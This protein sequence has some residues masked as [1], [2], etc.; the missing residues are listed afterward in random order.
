LSCENYFF[1]KPRLI[2]ERQGK[3]RG[4]HKSFRTAQE[5]TSIRLTGFS[6]LCQGQPALLGVILPAPAL[7][8]SQTAGESGWRAW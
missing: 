6:V 2:Q 7:G 1:K 8:I 5:N 4:F 3:E